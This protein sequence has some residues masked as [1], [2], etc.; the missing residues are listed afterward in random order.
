MGMAQV[1]QQ[2]LMNDLQR[3]IDNIRGELA[4]VELL[5]AALAGLSRPVP[6]YKPRFHHLGPQ[7]LTDHEL[8]QP[9]RA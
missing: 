7:R 1:P 2:R 4:R 6:E 9:R 8:S 5:A 3:A